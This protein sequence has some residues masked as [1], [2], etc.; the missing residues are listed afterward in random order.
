MEIDMA[1]SGKQGDRNWQSLPKAALRLSFW[2]ITLALAGASAGAFEITESYRDQLY[3]ENSHLDEWGSQTEVGRRNRLEFSIGNV[4]GWECSRLSFYAEVQ[5]DY[6]RGK[7]IFYDRG[8]DTVVGVRWT[9]P[10]NQL[11][12]PK[13]LPHRPAATDGCSVNRYPVVPPPGEPPPLK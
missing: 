13:P 10:L 1:G 3:G 4:F 5:R 2:A 8:I 11:F 12:G 7:D 6:D 9:V